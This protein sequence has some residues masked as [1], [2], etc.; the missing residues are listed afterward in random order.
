[1]KK[2][3]LAFHPFYRISLQPRYQHIVFPSTHQMLP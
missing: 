1:M 3:S 2:Y